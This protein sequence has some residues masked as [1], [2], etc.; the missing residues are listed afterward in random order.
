MMSAKRR[1]QVMSNISKYRHNSFGLLDPFF[2]DFL[3]DYHV[4][5]EIMRT[6][7]IEEEND[8]LLKIE[9]P[10]IK[11]ENIKLSLSEGYL[12]VNVSFKESND[13]KHHGKFLRRERH[14]GEASRS[15]YVG[16]NVKQEDVSASLENGILTLV[17]K[18]ETERVP[19]KT[20]IEI[21]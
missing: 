12:T 14:Y 13:E 1:T 9:V 4:S 20:Y 6:D 16:E 11:K 18:K 19:D 17:V 10:D 8:Y 5:N 15:F 7:I 2:D 3:G 21:K